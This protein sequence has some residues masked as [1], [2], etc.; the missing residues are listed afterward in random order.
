L[1]RSPNTNLFRADHFAASRM[2]QSALGIAID[3]LLNCDQ[4]GALPTLYGAAAIKVVDGGYYGPRGLFETRG[5]V[6][7]RR[8]SPVMQE[9]KPMQDE[10]GRPVSRWLE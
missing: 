3:T 1:A 10:S 8:A 5:Q 4:A 7:D 2:V 6:W 9:T